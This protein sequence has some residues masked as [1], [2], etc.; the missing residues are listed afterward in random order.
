M[1]FLKEGRKK[2]ERKKVYVRYGML[3]FQMVD[4]QIQ[5]SKLCLSN[6]EEIMRIRVK[7]WSNAQLFKAMAAL[8]GKPRIYFQYQAC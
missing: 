3:R 1:N 5:I 2:E 4:S 7:S 8:S 6:K